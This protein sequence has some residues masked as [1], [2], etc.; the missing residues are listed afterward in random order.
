MSMDD[1]WKKMYDMRAEKD[2]PEHALGYWSEPGYLQLLRITLQEVKKLD[3]KTVLDVGCGVGR[4]CHEISSLGLDITGTDYSEKLLAKAIENYPKLRFLHANGYNLPFE[5]KSFDLVISIGALQC[6]ED[7][8]GFI[9]ELCRVAAKN[10]II[11]TLLAEEK[12]DPDEELKELLEEDSWPTRDY[13][14]EILIEIFKEFGFDSEIIL[15]EEDKIITDGFFI[16]A[17]RK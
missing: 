2:M 17:K 13:H 5:D 1:E 4:Y 12:K 7:Y 6:L 10:I 9:K 11:S 3:V 15:K 16:A 14:P 8:K